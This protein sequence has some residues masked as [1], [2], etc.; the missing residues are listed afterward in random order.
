MR[1][2]TFIIS[3]KNALVLEIYFLSENASVTRPRC[4]NAKDKTEEYILKRKE[5]E[6]KLLVLEEDRIFHTCHKLPVSH[7]LE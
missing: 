5:L 1:Y 4:G 7:V 3:Y 2:E 6:K